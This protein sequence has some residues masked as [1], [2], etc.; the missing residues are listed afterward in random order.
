[1]VAKKTVKNDASP[2]AID[3]AKSGV[4]NSDAAGVAPAAP[5]ASRTL[6]K[7]R[8]RLAKA[9]KRPLDKKRKNERAVQ[10]RFSLLPEDVVQL[11]EL[12]QRLTSLGM[13]VKKSELAR[14]GLMLL[15]AL[16]NDDLAVIVERVKTGAVA[17]R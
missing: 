16:D 10:E 15:S 9:F 5:E 12:K 2:R 13:S 7:K 6:T 1:M 4:A 8:K 14:A 17:E 3:G 11:V